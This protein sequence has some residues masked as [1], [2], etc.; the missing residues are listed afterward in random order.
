[1]SDFKIIGNSN[2][3]VGK[4]EFYTI[5]SFQQDIFPSQQPIFNNSFEQP[6]KWEVYVLEHGRWRKTKENDK[7]GKKVSYTF[8]Q[9]SLTRDGIRI[10]ARRGDDVT[11]LNITPHPAEK[12]KIESIELLDKNGQKPVKPLSYGQ[13]LKARV[14]CLHMEKQK[15][16][17]T[18]WEDDA[19]GAGHNKANEK[20]II[21]TLSA[22]VKNGK[23]D[24]EFLL[25]PSFAKIA[26]KSKDEGA[27]H[28]YY[29]TTDFNKDKIASN[30]VN[31]NDLDAP[32][33]PYKSKVSIQ[34]SAPTKP[35]TSSTEPVQ[36]K[37]ETPSSGSSSTS[38]TKAEITNVHFTD[39]AGHA[40]SGVF[41]DKQ[42][43][44]WIDSKGLIGKEIRLKLYDEDGISNDLLFEEKFIV[45]SNIYSV[46]VPLN[47]IPRSKGGGYWGEGAEQELFADVEVLQT[48]DHTKSEVVDVDAKVFKPDPVE[49]TNK[50]AKV[51]KGGKN[52][53]KNCG[54][55]YCIK[56]GDKSELIR[57]INI[58]LAG[59]GGNVPTDEFTDRTE[60]MIKQFQRDYMKVPET[61]KVCGNVLKAIDDFQNKFPID[62]TEAKCKCGKCT[63]FGDASN[64]GKYSDKNI[65]AFHKYEYPGIHRSLLSSLRSV[66]FY[67]TK[68]GRYSFNKINSGYRCRFHPEYLKKATTNHMGK[69]LDLHFNYKNGRTKKTTDMEIIRKDIFNKYLDA[70]WDWK[71]RNIFNLESSA[72]GAVTWVHYDVREFDSVYLSDDLFVKNVNDLNGKSIVALAT[73]L[74]FVKTCNCLAE[75]SAI[76]NEKNTF[77]SKK[78]KWAHSE[79]G[80]LIAMKESSDNYNICNKT[81]GGYQ[82]I[83]NVKVVELTIEEVQKKQ[84]DR[85]LFAVGRYQLIPNTLNDAVDKLT[86][87]IDQKLDEEMQDKIFDEYLITVKRPNIIAYLENDGS[88]EDAMYA[89][90]MEWASIGVQKGKR[91]SDKLVKNDNKITKTI[92]YAEGGESYYAGDGLNKAH[93]TPEQIKTTLIN[94]KNENR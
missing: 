11:R 74:G 30:N 17:V 75:Y 51:G 12:P 56:K 42:I 43:K 82:L 18:L 81:K 46:V 67:L 8:L 87:D 22:V 76:M 69:A 65:E 60:K 23:A 29:V 71:T 7:T 70:K 58:R 25:K 49:V 5:N 31:V 90:A 52:D 66:K 37:T 91:I 92:R 19:I 3:L 83:N 73:E 35:K 47:Q 85:D 89:S 13:T 57:E 62:F 59:F 38:K 26:N 78:Y 45:K 1:M 50:V 4:E 48:K 61:G 40:I 34:K 33:A 55:K 84:K 10:L 16:F 77:K 86:L 94:S 44:V 68:D 63:G 6:I 53:R 27:I 79:F 64:K 39:T 88:V 41:K 15:I 14:H 54:E 93:I 72:I 20:N 9:K 36:S 80:N 21:Q 32:V 24:V 28:E 2:P